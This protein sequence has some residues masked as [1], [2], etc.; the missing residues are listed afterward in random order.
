MED[1]SNEYF[2]CLTH[3]RVEPWDGCRS[4]ERLGP[5]PTEADAARALE[6]AEERNEAW[7]NDPRFNDDEDVDDDGGDDHGALWNATH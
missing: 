1:H 6:T 5:Y 4:A 3:H 2:W 7:E